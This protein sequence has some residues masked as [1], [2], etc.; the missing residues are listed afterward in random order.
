MQLKPIDKQV[1]VLFGA[2]SGIGRLAA[3]QFARRGAQVVVAARSE[4]GLRSLVQEIEAAGGEALAVS[5]DTTIFE[6]VQAVADQAVNRFGRIDTWVHLAAVSIYSRFD[7][8]TPE[9]WRQVIDVNLNGQAYG[10]MVALPHLKREGRGALIHISS[11]LGQRAIPLQSAYSASKHGVVGMLDALRVELMQQNIPISV[12]NVV[13]ASINTPFFNHART[14][15]GLQPAPYPPVYQPELVAD[16][17]LHA[18]EHPIRDIFVG[19]GGKALITSHHLSP[20]LIDLLFKLTAWDLQMTSSPRTVDDP[21]AMFEP[22]EQFHRIKGDFGNQAF[23]FS[24]YPWMQIQQN[25]LFEMGKQ[26]LN[27]ADNILASLVRNMDQATRSRTRPDK[28]LTN[29]Q[30][31]PIETTDTPSRS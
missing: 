28:A 1:V 21:D 11:V 4:D 15:L 2:S 3:R 8:M 27:S 22:M 25:L 12:T 29:G 5:A 9:E 10:A 31:I 6:Q 14:R 24:L 18:A 30:R 23:S 13:P 17:I 7:H 19:E 26:M 16:A 20:S